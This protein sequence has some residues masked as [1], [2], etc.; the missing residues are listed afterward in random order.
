MV[1]TRN[2][3]TSCKRDAKCVSVSPRL[4]FSTEHSVSLLS[5]SETLA[6]C[7]KCLNVDYCRFCKNKH[8]EWCEE[9]RLGLNSFHPNL[10]KIYIS[11]VFFILFLVFVFKWKVNMFL[12]LRL[13]LVFNNNNRLFFFLFYI[14]HSYHNN[15]N[16]H[17]FFFFFF[18][19][20]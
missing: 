5:Q 12:I 16:N 13:R 11:I 1:Q 20:F 18:R 17:N 10:E 8:T 14:L 19:F 4:P 6:L 9:T 7:F 15:L 2:F 3:T